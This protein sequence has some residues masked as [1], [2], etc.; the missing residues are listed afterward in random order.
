M[1]NQGDLQTEWASPAP[2]PA[3]VT[4][5][6]NI[7]LSIKIYSSTIMKVFNRPG[8]AGAVLQTPP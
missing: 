4:A 7:I 3:P 6:T 5:F 2:A 1:L 8:V